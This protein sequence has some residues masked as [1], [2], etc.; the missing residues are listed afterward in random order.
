MKLEEIDT[1]VGEVATRYG[2]DKH[3]ILAVIEV[4][5]ANSPWATRFEPNWS[6]LL[7]PDR[8]CA[9]T[10]PPITSETERVM[11]MMSWGLMQVMGSVARQYGFK[12]NLSRLTDPRVNIELGVRHFARFNARDMSDQIAAYNAGQPKKLPNGTYVNQR[13]VDKVVNAWTRIRSNLIIK[14]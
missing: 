4:E 3:L 1:L 13:Y 9:F 5:S 8:H 14:P 7:N 6:Y 2:V 11:Q 12:E 10:T